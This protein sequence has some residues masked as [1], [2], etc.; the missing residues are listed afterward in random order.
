MFIIQIQ[1]LRQTMRSHTQVSGMST[2][3]PHNLQC[4]LRSCVIMHVS[5]VGQ[6][7]DGSPF[8]GGGPLAALDYGDKN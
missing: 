8:S 2:Y 3:E 5:C 4:L 1:I 7:K 6:P